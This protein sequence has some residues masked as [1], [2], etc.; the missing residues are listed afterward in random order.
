[1]LKEQTEEKQKQFNELGGIKTFKEIK[2]QLAERDRML[3]Y[4]EQTEKGGSMPSHNN[5]MDGA[6]PT[7]DPAVQQEL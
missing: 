6:S 7:L 3:D 1:M 2:S 5:L 4:I